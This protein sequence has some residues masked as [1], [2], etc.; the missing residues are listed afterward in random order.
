[1]SQPVWIVVCPNCQTKNEI[2]RAL[3]RVECGRALSDCQCKNC[4]ES[5]PVRRDLLEWLGFEDPLPGN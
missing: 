1:M 4:G 3:V 5:F 2:E